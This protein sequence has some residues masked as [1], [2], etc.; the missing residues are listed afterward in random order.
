ML[1]RLSCTSNTPAHGHLSSFLE[2]SYNYVEDEEGKHLF[3]LCCLFEE[4][5]SIL[6]EDLARYTLGLS[7][8][9]GISEM[10]KARDRV[11]A[12]VDDLKSRYLLLDGCNDLVRELVIGDWVKG[13]QRLKH[14]EIH[15]CDK[16]M[17]LV[18]LPAAP[19]PVVFPTLEELKLSM[20]PNLDGICCGPVP[21]GSFGKLTEIDVDNC[22]ELRNLFLLPVL[23]ELE[24]E[25]CGSLRN[26]F[27]FSMAGGLV[28]LQKLKIRNCLE[29]EVVVGGEEEIEDG[30]DDQLSQL[31]KIHISDCP[32]MDAF[33]LKELRNSSSS[34][35][36]LVDSKGKGIMQSKS[37]DNRHGA[38]NRGSVVAG[39]GGTVEEVVPPTGKIITPNLRIFT[40]AELKS[41][42]RN[43]G[44]DTVLGEKDSGRFSR[45]GWIGRPWRRRSLASECRSPSRNVGVGKNSE[46]ARILSC[47]MRLKLQWNI[48]WELDSCLI[49][50][51]IC[52][53]FILALDLESPEILS[54][55]SNGN[56]VA[57]FHSMG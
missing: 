23:K 10:R 3:L 13:I 29:M 33:Y 47:V 2:L 45:V 4:D 28:N 22:G 27:H 14:L 21:A 9:D 19:I 1:D 26:M 12:L 56:P 7:L 11:F 50:T 17:F 53:S 25:D 38:E 39:G 49:S 40:Y 55:G 35:F 18:L 24:V 44:P 41:A 5:K 51:A 8:L 42:T 48:R 46:S 16:T 32:G 37:S 57:Y 52:T 6:L 36:L 34:W 54:L 30:Q 43:F 20:L 15:D 31:S